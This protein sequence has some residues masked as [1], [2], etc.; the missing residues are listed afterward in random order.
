MLALPGTFFESLPGVNL[1]ILS[2]VMAPFM[3]ATLRISSFLIASPIFSI[4]G[5]PLQIRIVMSLCIT[6]AVASTV[7]IPDIQEIVGAKLAIIAFSEIA[8]GLVAGLILYIVFS[9][10]ALA[11]EKMAATGGLGFASLL[12]PETGAQSPV[13]AQLLSLFMLVAFVSLDGHLIVLSAIIQSYSILPIGGTLHFDELIETGI[14]AGSVMFKFA[15]LIMLPVVVGL[16]LINVLIG[17]ITRSAPTLNLFSFGFPITLMGSFFILY[18][19]SDH[20][21]YALANLIEVASSLVL[22][23]FESAS[24]G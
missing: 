8:I 20:I 15:A 1:Q 22:D 6:L 24:N 13:L 14:S 19:S 2:Q 4:R 9:A 11:G 17:V 7:N 21:A 3:L 10:A 16:T 12:D 5:L 18:I 23:L